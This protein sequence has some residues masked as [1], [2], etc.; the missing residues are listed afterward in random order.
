[1]VRVPGGK[2]GLRLP[3]L[4]H[5]RPVVLGDYAMDRTEVTNR[6][7]KRFV[8]EGGY[9]RREL[10]KEPFVHGKRTLGWDEA[11]ALLHDRTGRPGPPPGI[12][13]TTRRGRATIRSPA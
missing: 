10:W 9:R 5:L 6:Q 12:W 4:D 1:M 11:M 7:F 2:E 13:G 3:G 8:D